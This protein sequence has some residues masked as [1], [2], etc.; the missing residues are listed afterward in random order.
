MQSMHTP[1][2]A[3]AITNRFIPAIA[4]ARGSGLSP[5]TRLS[6]DTGFIANTGPDRIV[7]WKQ[8]SE[9]LHYIQMNLEQRSTMPHF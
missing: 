5:P 9:S 3:L 8:G 2:L 7:C 4:Y 6:L 1:H